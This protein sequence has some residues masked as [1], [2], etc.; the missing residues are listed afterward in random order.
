MIY[1]TFDNRFQSR[2]FSANVLI[3]FQHLYCCARKFNH[4]NLSILK[5]G[6]YVALDGSLDVDRDPPFDHLSIKHP[7][8][9]KDRKVSIYIRFRV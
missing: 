5:S 7:F 4:Y 3:Y 6:T 1:F 2:L 8:L 9:F